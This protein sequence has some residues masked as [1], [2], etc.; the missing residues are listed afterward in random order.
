MSEINLRRLR[1]SRPGGTWRD[2]EVD[3][4]APCHRQPAG[5]GYASVYGRMRGD[6]P[7]PTVTTQ[8]FAFGSGRFGHPD[9]DRALS[10]R[11]GALLQSFPRDY[12]FVHPG[13]GSNLSG[14]AE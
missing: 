3:L 1:A 13:G 4:V 10:L 12:A 8:F 9:Q 5:R 2:W 7:S 11:E 6:G 14:W